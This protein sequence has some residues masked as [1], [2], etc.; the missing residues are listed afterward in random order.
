MQ[1]YR[2]VS[3][4]DSSRDSGKQIFSSN[5]RL[6]NEEEETHRQAKL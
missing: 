4:N 6:P 5:K 3:G 2:I 1:Y